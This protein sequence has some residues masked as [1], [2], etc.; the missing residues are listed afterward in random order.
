MTKR[1]RMLD[2]A[3]GHEEPG[4]VPGAFF[5]HFD[6]AFHR[7]QAAVEKHMEYFRATDM[8]FVKIQYE[9][10][11]P[12]LAQIARPE[13]WKTVPR[14]DE[15]YFSEPLDVVQGIVDA[16]NGEALVIVTLYSAL[17]HAAHA[18][19][20]E[21]LTDHLDKDPAQTARGLQLINQSILV[22][23]REC[24]KRGVDGFYASTQGG[25]SGRF[26][27][28][29]LFAKVI[30]PLDL[31][32]MSEIDR[33]ARFN[34]LHVCDYQGPYDE[35]SPYLDYPGHIV[36][37]PTRLR[38]GTRTPRQLAE[39]FKRPFMGGLDR[40]GLIAT[41][42]TAQ[43]VQE[44]KKVLKDVPPAFVLGADCTVPSDSPLQNL[45]AAIDTAHGS[46]SSTV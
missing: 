16:V 38:S 26:K 41:G 6:A 14:L 20:R 9:H 15:K 27:D 5:L 25:E 34:I 45:R 22:F 12:V 43:V 2:L 42:T 36:N 46:S 7:G 37:C 8:D 28:P 1:D 10:P 19:S 39:M 30:K 44:T 11:F 13:D 23:V 32:V 24:L 17:M 4:Y 40:L 18:T 35:L 3:D 33:R 21:T 29:E 31:E